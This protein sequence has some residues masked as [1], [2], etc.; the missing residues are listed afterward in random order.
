M[1][2]EKKE[3]L[4]CDFEVRGQLPKEA[5]ELFAFAQ[6]QILGL[7]G[8]ISQVNE[9]CFKGQL[10]GEGQVIDAFKKLLTSAAEY[11]DAVK[12]F[13]IKNLKVIKEY[14]FESFEVQVK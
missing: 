13:I 3:I 11:V 5:F 10:Q 14:T 6:A 2:G 9:N 8:Y 7:R 4:S 12:E 1:A